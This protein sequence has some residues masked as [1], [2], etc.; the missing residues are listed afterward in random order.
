MTTQKAN[1]KASWKLT[2]TGIGTYKGIDGTTHDFDWKLLFPNWDNF[3]PVE[4][5]L[6]DYGCK[7]AL[8]DS[9]ADIGKGATVADKITAM[10]ERFEL[11]ASGEIAKKRVG[12]GGVSMKTVKN[13]YQDLTE[14]E[15]A[16]ADALMAKLGIPAIK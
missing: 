8:A 12:G 6:A 14:A 4:K 2:D 11:L 9:I 1:K 7:Q 16:Q 13:N 3:D 15:K 5:Y 10:V